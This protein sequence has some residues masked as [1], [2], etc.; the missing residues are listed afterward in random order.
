M[1]TTSIA[2]LSPTSSLSDLLRSLFEG[3]EI[4]WSTLGDGEVTV[5]LIDDRD[6]P[7]ESELLAD[8]RLGR[9]PSTK[10]ERL[11]PLPRARPLRRHPKIHSALTDKRLDIA[12]RLWSVVRTKA[13]QSGLAVDADIGVEKGVE[14]KR[15]QAI[16]AVH[17]LGNASQALALWKSLD[18]DMDRWLARLPAYDRNVLLHDV[19]LRFSWVE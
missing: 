11:S 18:I 2:S 5:R 6:K 8:H 13:L 7:N 16:L 12:N 15:N 17:V 3:Q 1:V 4:V 10:R 14:D 9:I 19:G